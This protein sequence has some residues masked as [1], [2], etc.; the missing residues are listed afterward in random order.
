MPPIYFSTWL[1]Q[2]R[3]R[4]D[5]TADIA[6]WTIMIKFYKSC[7]TYDDFANLFIELAPKNIISDLPLLKEEFLKYMIARKKTKHETTKA[8]T[9]ILASLFSFYVWIENPY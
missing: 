3:S 8:K 4:I 7:K 5:K 6:S 1:M 2:Q 9:L